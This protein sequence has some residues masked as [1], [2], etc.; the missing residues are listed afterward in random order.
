MRSPTPATLEGSTQ[1]ADEG[2][3][4][5]TSDSR[6]GRAQLMVMVGLFV[7]FAGLFAYGLQVPTPPGSLAHIVPWLAVGFLT[8]WTGG[9]LAGNSLVP[10]PAGVSPA[11]RAQPGIAMVATLAGALAAG[12][13]LQRL[14]PWAS[15]SPGAPAELWIA[16]AGAGLVWLGGFLMGHSMRRFGR[17]RRR[18][19]GFSRPG[20]R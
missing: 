20:E 16:A 9:I 6:R 3:A 19:R 10:P 11:L 4:L 15:L 1:P 17:R 14:G 8:A 2:P 18:P 5:D 12:V 7:T 13:V